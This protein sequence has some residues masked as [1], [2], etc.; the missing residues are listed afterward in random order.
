[1]T[2]PMT[3]AIAPARK[4]PEDHLS[5]DYVALLVETLGHASETAD[6]ETA[7]R[8]VRRI[9]GIAMQSPNPETFLDAVV[10]EA[11][12]I[13][14]RQDPACLE[15]FYTQVFPQALCTPMKSAA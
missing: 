14:D 2:S 5:E 1:M 3:V 15:W 13:W 6:L 4:R 8:C 12:E 7:I 10:A 11:S 9:M